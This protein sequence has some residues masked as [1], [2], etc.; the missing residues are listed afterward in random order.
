MSGLHAEQM[1]NEVRRGIQDENDQ[2]RDLSIEVYVQIA[3][4][5]NG[6]EFILNNGIVLDIAQLFDDKIESIR[7]KAYVSL[8]YLSDERSGCEGVVEEGAIE[9][10]VD[11]LLS[12]KSEKILIL[13]MSLIKSLL[14]VTRGPIRSLTTPLISRLKNFLVNPS[15]QL[16]KLAAENLA[17]MAFSYPGKEKVIEGGCVSPLA[18]LMEDEDT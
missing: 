11:K 17:E 15:T 18:N 9:I 2:I 7:E 12:E 6:R 1:M 13:T 16:K 4:F 8:W 3:K 5:K 14:K 10:L